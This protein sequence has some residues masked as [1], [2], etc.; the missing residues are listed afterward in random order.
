MA[1]SDCAKRMLFKEAYL[2]DDIKKELEL[3][4]NVD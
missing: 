3:W 2:T 1:D 4:D